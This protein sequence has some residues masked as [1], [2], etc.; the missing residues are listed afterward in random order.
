MNALA[1]FAKP[2]QRGRARYSVEQYYA[3]CDALADF[4]GARTELIGGEIYQ[5]NAQYSPHF[6]LKSDLGFEIAAIL[7]QAGSILEVC[8][9]G[10]VELGDDAAPLPDIIVYE[11]NS[12]K[13][14]IPAAHLRLIVEVADSS[15]KFD[16]G[17]KKRLYA[18]AMVP[19]YWVAVLRTGKLERFWEPD[20]KDYMQR[21]SLDLY[22][23]IAS[24]T[25]TG[26]SIVKGSLR[27]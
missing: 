1:T 18:E 4:G 19:E 10:T 26:L 22:G 9:E 24:R 14:G 27:R 8:I 13:K 16:L 11:P 3:I 25:V 5:M 12:S 15:E 17:K 21:D 20:S 7:K 6:R 2:A 23:A